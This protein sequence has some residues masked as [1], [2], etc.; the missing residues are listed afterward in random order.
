MRKSAF[1]TIR[2]VQSLTEAETLLG[3]LRRAC[4]H[5]VDLSL[6]SPLPLTGAEESFPIEVPAEEADLARGLLEAH[7]NLS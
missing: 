3:L 6:S 2:T 4:L 7:H 1:V 5:P